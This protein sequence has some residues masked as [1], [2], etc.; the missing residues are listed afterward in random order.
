MRAYTLSVFF[1]ESSAAKVVLGC[2][3]QVMQRF[4]QMSEILVRLN[5]LNQ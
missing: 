4:Q 1:V 2:L 3:Q 5:E